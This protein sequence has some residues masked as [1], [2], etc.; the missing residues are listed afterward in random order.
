MTKNW[1]NLDLVKIIQFCLK[2]HDLW[3]CPHLWMYG[4]INGWGQVK[5]LK[6]L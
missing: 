2:I 5:L 3:E 1:I 6:I 4:W